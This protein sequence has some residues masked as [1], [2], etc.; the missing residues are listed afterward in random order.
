[1]RKLLLCL[2][3]SATVCSTF[4]EDV[5]GGIF[6]RRRCRRHFRRPTCS[7]RHYAPPASCC[8]APAHTAATYCICPLYRYAN[9]GSYCSY[10]SEKCKGTYCSVDAGC[11][12]PTGGCSNCNNSP[13]F[14]MSYATRGDYVHPNFDGVKTYPTE[15]ANPPA[16]VAIQGTRYIKFEKTFNG[17]KRMVYAK[18][19]H[20][21]LSPKDF[22][23]S[24]KPMNTFVGFEID[25][26]QAPATAASIQAPASPGKRHCFKANVGGNSYQVVTLAK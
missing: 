9:H 20:Y 10:Y 26:S 15:D 6:R 16:G 8:Q 1:M 13:C 21:R 17:Q 25:P 18:L 14:T 7:Q 22:G 12:I 5:E 19:L 11:A 24:G 3:V 23:Q 4:V 2:L